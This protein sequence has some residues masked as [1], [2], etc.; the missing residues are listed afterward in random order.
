M[1]NIFNFKLWWK[2]IDKINFILISI[3][4]IIGIILSFS[5]NESSIFFNKHLV[6]AISSLFIMIFLSSLDPKT[7]RRI[8]LFFLIIF[9]F[10]LL[11]V[12]I[13]DNEIKGSSRWLKFLGFSLGGSEFIKPF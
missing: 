1:N 2:E 8:S 11:I 12:L 13:F 9:I 7:L 10:A 3:L 6:F 4:L 5:L